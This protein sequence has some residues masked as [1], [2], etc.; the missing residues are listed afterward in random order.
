[1]EFSKDMDVSR[2]GHLLGGS[3][4]IAGTA[5]GGGMLAL[6]VLT[7]AGGFFPAVFFF[8]LC[9]LFMASTGLLLMEI[10]LW[11]KEEVNI[12]SMA[13]MTLGTPGKIVAW[14]LYLFLF[15]SLTIAYVSGGGGLVGDVFEALGNPGYPRW[16]GPLI[17]VL[18]FAPFV[19]IGPK[20]AD[21][22][23]SLM[24]AGLIISFLI[25]VVLGINHI[26]LHLLSHIN[27]P[28]AVLAVPVIFTS[29]GFQ[30]I[31]PTLT[32][33]LNRN[34]AY[35]KKAIVIGS[36]I[37][38]ICYIIWEGLILGV[39]QP[40]GL[41]EALSIGQSAV[42][43]L[44]NSVGMP[45]LFR[46]GEFFGFFAIVTSFLGVT[47]GLLDFLADGL[48][49]KKTQGGRVLLSLLI[50]IPPLVLA[51]YNP[52]LF[53]SALHYAGGLGGALLLG[54]LPILMVWRGRYKLKFESSYTLFGGRIVLSLLILFIIFELIIMLV[55][56]A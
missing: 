22:V 28:M 37:P 14:I 44:K 1:M 26:E 36:L 52:Y 11:S 50:Y 30:G 35:V 51:M 7:A 8:I 24:M 39:I 54:L 31:V 42:Y 46:V 25:F 41:E 18:I 13:Q 38:L 43:P 55:K 15:Y 23:N 17:F 53:L 33:Y 45:W 21:K 3:L 12:I 2:G 6:P 32:T 4:L 10:F 16:L 48:K 47:L 29:F 34:P 49:I 5:I 9:W 56:I 19:I 20:A 40:A 27:M